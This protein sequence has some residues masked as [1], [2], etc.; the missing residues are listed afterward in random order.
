[1]E[2]G[3]DQMFIVAW[4]ELS[5]AGNKVQRWEI[6]DGED[7]M[8]VFVHELIEQSISEDEIVCGITIV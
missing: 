1:M 4:N 5:D 3:E 2:K 6:I 7:A 8:Q